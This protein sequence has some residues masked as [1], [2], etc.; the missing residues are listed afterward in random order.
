MAKLGAG[1]RAEA[2]AIAHERGLLERP[3]KLA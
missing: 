2:V 3:A 1:N